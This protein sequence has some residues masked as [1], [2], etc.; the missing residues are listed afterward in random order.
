MGRIERSRLIELG[1]AEL[2]AAP[3]LAAAGVVD[4]ESA[5]GTAAAD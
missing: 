5:S 1:P 2:A 3:R 4:R